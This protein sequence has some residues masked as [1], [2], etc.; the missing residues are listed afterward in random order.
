MVLF[1]LWI[2]RLSR[3]LEKTTENYFC[4]ELASMQYFSIVTES[5]FGRLK[6]IH[7]CCV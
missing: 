3:V 1:L 2:E 7:S 5:D 6:M 4:M